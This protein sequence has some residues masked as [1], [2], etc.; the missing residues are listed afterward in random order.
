MPEELQEAM[1]RTIPGLD[2]VKMVRPAYGVEYDFVDPRELT[3]AYSCRIF[4]SFIEIVSL[5]RR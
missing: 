5:Q 4:P 2:N 1:L 3:C